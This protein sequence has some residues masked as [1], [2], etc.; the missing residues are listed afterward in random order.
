M[1]SDLDE[2]EAWL[3][4]PDRH[5]AGVSSW[6][7]HKQ[8]E[9]TALVAR[10]ILELVRGLEAGAVG[11]PGGRIRWPAHLVLALGWIPRGKGVAPPS[12]LPGEA[13][14]PTAIRS[15]L[16]DVRA[17]QRTR[18]T[19]AGGNRAAHPHFGALTARQW[20]RFLGIH[21]RHHLKIIRDIDRAA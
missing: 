13:P 6:S 20:L 19:P 11:E 17:R 21:T 12:V 2:L 18:R 3:A 9:H 5:A 10:Q 1:K 8:V 4:K 16:A 14:D 15:I 7:I